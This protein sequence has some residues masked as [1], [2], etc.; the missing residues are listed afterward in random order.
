M[1]D[2][3]RD[4]ERYWYS[5][6]SAAPMPES[7]ER[8]NIGVLVGNG[9]VTAL[10]FKKKLPRLAGIAA[11]DAVNVY[12]AVLETV[13]DMIRTR[14][15]EF[16]SVSG[17]LAPQLVLGECRD[18]ARAPDE[19]LLERL[20]ERFLSAPKQPVRENLEALV[21]RSVAKLD[22]HLNRAK[23]PGVL[24][25][26]DVRLKNLYDGKIQRH[27][28]YHVPHLARA[29]R[30]SFGRDA[31]IDSLAV[32][33]ANDVQSVREAAGRIGQAFNAYGGKLRPLIRAQ[34]NSELRLVGVLHPTPADAS[35]DSIA[36]RDYI[37]ESW[38]R[39]AEVIDGNRTDIESALR[40]LG[41]WVGGA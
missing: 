35:P 3:F 27:V 12:V 4:T 18:L 33:S 28:L 16:D 19:A 17:I 41:A 37:F 26:R 22:V 40:E 15:M 30:G 13:A 6:V 21:T 8:V 24:I 39:D 38:S 10:R 7:G 14:P 29:F 32:E 31:L 11:A 2:L 9:H 34:S 23:P 5:L 20:T 25:D 1:H 36:I